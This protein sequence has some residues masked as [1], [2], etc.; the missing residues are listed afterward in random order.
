MQGVVGKEG[1]VNKTTA[2]CILC[3]VTFGMIWLAYG[4]FWSGIAF[5]AFGLAAVLQWGDT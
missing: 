3:S 1:R 4:G 2:A 5:G